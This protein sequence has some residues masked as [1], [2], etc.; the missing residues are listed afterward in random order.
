MGL[1]VF[2]PLAYLFVLNC[3]FLCIKMEAN[4]TVET[5]IFCGFMNIFFCYQY[6]FVKSCLAVLSDI[7]MPEKIWFWNRDVQSDL[8]FFLHYIDFLLNQIIYVLRPGIDQY[9]FKRYAL[10]WWIVFFFEL[11]KIITLFRRDTSFDFLNKTDRKIVFAIYSRD[12]VS[13]VQ[14]LFMRSF[15]IFDIHRNQWK[16]IFSRSLL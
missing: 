14:I 5:G 10:T 2:L 9:A 4:I 15:V 3:V 12:H 1:S 11:M 6:F 7:W 16:Q 13:V 8:F